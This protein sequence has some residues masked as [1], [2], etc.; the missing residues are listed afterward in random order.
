MDKLRIGII[1]DPNINSNQGGAFSYQYSL[2]EGI[3]KYSFSENLDILFIVLYHKNKPIQKFQKPVIYIKSPLFSPKSPSRETKKGSNPSPFLWY[4]KKSIWIRSMVDMIKKWLWIDIENQ[5]I[6]QE[7][8]IVFPLVPRIIP[9]N[10]PLILNH[11]DIG[12]LSTYAFPEFASGLIFNERERYYQ[13]HLKKAFL[14]LCES[15]SGIRELQKFY[16]FFKQRIEL[17]P[18]FPSSMVHSSVDSEMDSHILKEWGLRKRAFFFYP[19]QFWSHKNHYNLV[20]SFEDISK[21]FPDVKLV[22]SGYD[23]G[24]MDYI[25]NEIEKRKLNSCIILTGF[26]KIEIL[27]IFYK[28]ALALVM[29]SFL[30]PTNMPIMEAALLNCP[31]ICSDLE[32]HREIMGDTAIYVDP[33][34]FQSIYKGMKRILN[35]DFNR[36]DFIQNAFN[37]V[38]NSKFSLP[39]TLESLDRIFLKL[40]PIRKTWGKLS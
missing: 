12:H 34:D 1:L 36:E 3:D 24:N 19:A 10:M 21:E 4:F 8:E 26:V 18:I 35:P 29:P 5:I 32:G 16:P 17:L 38:K 15:E 25:K 11:W 22:L 31:V 2:M 30:G 33:E 23:M 13:D 40:Y 7:I 14:I 9:I 20:R 37:Q 27:N 6:K 28:N 39:N